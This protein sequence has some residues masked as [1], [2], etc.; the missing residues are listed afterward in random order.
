MHNILIIDDDPEDQL[1]ARRA[2]RKGQYGSVWN[3]ESTTTFEQGCEELSSGK[4][5]TCI[6]DVNLPGRSGLELLQWC[7]TNGISI[8]VIV[9][10]GTDDRSL[11][12]AAQQAG[13]SA[14]VPKS[15]LSTG[16]L[17][18]AVRYSLVRNSTRTLLGELSSGFTASDTARANVLVVDD[19]I[20]DIALIKREL[21]KNDLL[22]WEIYTATT[23]SEAR[24]I[25]SEN[26]IDIC[27]V[28]YLLGPDRGTDLITQARDITNCHALF[29]VLTGMK[30]RFIDAEAQQLGAS[31]FIPK[32]SIAGGELERAVRYGLERARSESML[33]RFARALDSAAGEIYQVDLKSRAIQYMNRGAEMNTGYAV[34]EVEIED[35]LFKLVAE[36]EITHVRQQIEQAL[37]S[38]RVLFETNFR[39]KDGSLYPVNVLGEAS[40]VGGT[41][42][43]CIVTDLTEQKKRER[44][45]QQQ[46]KMEA[47][48]QLAGGIAHD[49]NNL[50]TVIAG[51]IELIQEEFDDGD[52]SSE[53]PELLSEIAVAAAQGAKLTSRLL[54]FSRNDESRFE[55]TNIRNVLNEVDLIIRRLIGE[56]YEVVNSVET[57]ELEVMSDFSALEHALI[58]LAVNSRDAMEGGGTIEIGVKP[59]CASDFPDRH[60]DIPMSKSYL[61][62]YVRDSGCGMSEYEVEH[63]FEPF[64]TSKPAGK[65][66]GLGLSM[67]YGV[68]KQSQGSAFV[69][70]SEGIGTT[71]HMI[72]RTCE[73]RDE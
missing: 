58:N 49:F 16:E 70:S 7:K 23:L 33:L 51:N 69:E 8:P 21:R 67:V 45:T 35:G 30:D 50:L 20:D 22:R 1:L 39:R 18:R 29:I 38:S 43:L 40:T 24:T 6:V 47:V 71:V 15:H 48:G 64:F 4:F 26:D 65:G 12:I 66:T 61:D 32:A 57:E 3:V 42:I 11:D 34:E 37:S 28:D 59:F 27:I 54:A 46:Q 5:D 25:L 41:Q 14:F 56:N 68:A 53:I 2:L 9:L 44:H 60:I 13:A 19:D 63:A 62:V 36:D 10:T 17:E 72:L 31:S 52:V 55:R 73:G